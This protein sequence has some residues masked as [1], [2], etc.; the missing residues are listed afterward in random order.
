MRHRSN[1]PPLYPSSPFWDLTLKQE[2]VERMSRITLCPGCRKLGIQ[3]CQAVI[4]REGLTAFRIAE[5]KQRR[6]QAAKE[7]L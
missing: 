6:E 5:E 7:K 4:G 1:T 3:L 2:D